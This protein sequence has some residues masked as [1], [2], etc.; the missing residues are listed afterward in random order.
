MGRSRQGSHSF[1]VYSFAF[2]ESSNPLQDAQGTL[3][4][5]CKLVEREA[6]L[7]RRDGFIARRVLA[8]REEHLDAL[9]DA[10]RVILG[11]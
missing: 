4:A 2:C 8:R 1:E 11:Q 3:K 7:V 6:L 5:K 9:H 10:L